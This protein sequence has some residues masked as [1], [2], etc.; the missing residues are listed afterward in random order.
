MQYYVHLD[1]VTH[2]LYL[3][4]D[5]VALHEEGVVHV[6]VHHPHHP[7]VVTLH[8][9]RVLLRLHE[10]LHAGEGGV[11]RILHNMENELKLQT[12]HR[13]SLHNHGEELLP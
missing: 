12:K 6:A 4:L 3:V 8:E 5:G 10:G 1:E 9:H 2:P 13:Q 7:R 11:L